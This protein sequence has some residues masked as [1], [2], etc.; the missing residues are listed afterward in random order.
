MTKIIGKFT[1]M[2]GFL[3]L[4]CHQL[5]KKEWRRKHYRWKLYYSKENISTTTTQTLRINTIYILKH[6][7]C[8]D[9]EH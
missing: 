1:S 6:I 3:S 2:F 7:L 8:A 4:F 9:W 5:N